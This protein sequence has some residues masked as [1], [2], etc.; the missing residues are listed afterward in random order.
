MGPADS[1]LIK[2]QI[3]IVLQRTTH[4]NHHNASQPPHSQAHRFAQRP[5]PDSLL[6]EPLP[7][8]RHRLL[9]NSRHRHRYGV[10][11][12]TLHG[13]RS[14][15][16]LVRVLT[17]NASGGYWISD[18]LPKHLKWVAA[19]ITGLES[20]MRKQGRIRS[21][22]D[23]KGFGFIAPDDGSKH[24]FIHINAFSNRNRKPKSGEVVTYVLSTDNQGRACAA[25]AI[26]EG[27]P[28]PRQKKRRMSGPVVIGAIL[29]LC[30][31]GG[32]VA[33]SKLPP[34][35][36]GVYVIASV[37][38]FFTYAVDKSAARRGAWRTS[39]STFHWLSFIGGWPGGLIA[40][41]TLHHKSR[42]SSFRSVFWVTVVL[43]L[44]VLACIL[45]PA[46][47]RTVQSW[48]S[49]SHSLIAPGKRATIEW[50]EP[51]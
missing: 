24:V 39:E 11:R 27:D 2:Q 16:I 17:L 12:E 37:V 1:Q 30:S 36:L 18:K 21:W 3:R 33:W 42:K 47:M 22:S 41:Q 46:G 38:T 5:L 34:I 25:K 20:E 51:R 6:K 15:F 19:A 29:F 44:A 50:A 26:S 32:L 8:N 9:D 40:Q 28:L 4:L 43:N 13:M 31:L 49:E 10:G 35:I 45:T 48:L 14:R 7:Y 23:Q